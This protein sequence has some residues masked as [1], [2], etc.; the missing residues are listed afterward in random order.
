MQF[1]KARYNIVYYLFWFFQ[2]FRFFIFIHY[3]LP[4]LQGKRPTV[5]ISGGG[6]GVDKT[7]RA[8][9]SLGIEKI[10]KMPQNP[11]RLLHILLGAGFMDT[12][13]Q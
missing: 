13:T 8:G 12:N 10:P 6:A 3:S 7:P 1:I 11:H 9:F 2:V 4:V 5:C